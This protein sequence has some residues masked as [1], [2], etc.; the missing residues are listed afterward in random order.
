MLINWLNNAV[1][2][3]PEEGKITVEATLKV[4]KDRPYLQMSV[5]DTGI[6]IA[7][8]NISKLFQPFIQVDSA[9]NRQYAGTGLGLSLVK[10]I[11]ELHG[12]E[13]GVTSQVGAGS[14]FTVQLPCTGTPT[15]VLSTARISDSEPLSPPLVPPSAVG[16][17]SLPLILL[18]EDNEAN[19][20][21]ISSYLRAK[22]Y[23]LIFAEN[24]EQA[25]GM[26]ELENPDLILLD[27]MMPGLDGIEVC[28]Q[29]K[30]L[31]KWQAIPIVMVTALSSKTD[32]AHCLKSGADDFISKPVNG[33]E[34]RARVHS[35][36][37]IK[38]LMLLCSLSVELMSNKG[39]VWV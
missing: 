35:M 27:V 23:R 7:P 20:S 29:I 25:I 30:A 24:G 31:P 4:E 39:S 2:F 10:R 14:C 5:T 33:I 11:V 13:V 26:A 9:L 1:K 3:T 16:P 8:E 17:E 36:L 19:I 32:L 34:L 6:G 12:G 15:W 22:G 18:A 37:R 21:T 28:R 38:Q